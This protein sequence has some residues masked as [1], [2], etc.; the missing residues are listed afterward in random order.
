[1]P[2]DIFEYTLPQQSAPVYILVAV[3]LENGEYYEAYLNTFNCPAQPFDGN[4]RRENEASDAR[5]TSARAF[6]VFPNPTTGLLY[7][8]LPAEWEAGEPAERGGM[9]GKEVKLLIVN[10]LGQIVF[11]QD[12]ASDDTI[13]RQ[14]GIVLERGLSNGMYLVS[15]IWPD[16]KRQSERFVLKR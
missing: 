13:G 1:V 2:S 4:R 15:V 11:Q 3:R 6:S 8:N 14:I 5:I 7:V 9:D 12:Y 10:S 16:G